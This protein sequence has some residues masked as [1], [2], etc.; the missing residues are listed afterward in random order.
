MINYKTFIIWDVEESKNQCCGRTSVAD[1]DP[2]VFGLSDPDPDLLVGC[3]D[4]DPAPDPST[5]KRNSKKTL[6]PILFCDLFMTFYLG[7]IM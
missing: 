4:L 6:I 1:L 5:I 3:T 2:Y 7:K